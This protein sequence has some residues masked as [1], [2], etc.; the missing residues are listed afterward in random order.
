MPVD[1][2]P[3]RLK[4][5]ETLRRLLSRLSKFDLSEHI[6]D[7]TDHLQAHGGHCDIFKAKS[8]KHGDMAVAVKRL[9]V[10]ILHDKDAAKIVVRELRIWSSLDHPN[11]LPLLGYVMHGSYPAS[12]SSWIIRKM[13]PTIL[14]YIALYSEFAEFGSV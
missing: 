11:V 4:H 12:I 7:Q 2:T 14:H 13:I 6:F 9:R 1:R 10:H 3:R 8:R 5:E